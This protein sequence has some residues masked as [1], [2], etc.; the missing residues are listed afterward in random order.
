MGAEHFA[1]VVDG[2]FNDFNSTRDNKYQTIEDC[3]REAIE[4]IEIK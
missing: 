4:N 3:L 1:T 2:Y